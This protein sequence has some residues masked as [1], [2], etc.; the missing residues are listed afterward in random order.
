[1]KF[2]NHKKTSSGFTLIEMLVAVFIFSVIMTIAIGAIFSIVNANKTSQAIKSVMDNLSSAV[3]SMSRNIRYGSNY[4]GFN[5]NKS[6]SFID[7]DG[8]NFGYKFNSD[9]AGSGYIEKCDGN[10]TTTSCFRLTAKE[11]NI[12][13]LYFYVRGAESADPN[14]HPM[15][16]I[17]ISGTAQA[18]SHSSEFNI[19]TLVSQRNQMCKDSMR[20]FGF[21]VCRSSI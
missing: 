20:P 18:G 8:N 10:F 11:V 1:M 9:D 19:E 4:Q 5:D 21:S 15:L 7:K 14:S 2:F 6:F 16:L 12:A 13:G 3:D 17:T